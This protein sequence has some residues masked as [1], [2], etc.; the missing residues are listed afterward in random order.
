[1]QTKRYTIE[2][3]LLPEDRLCS[4]IPSSDRRTHR[5]RGLADFAKLADFVE[6]DELMEKFLPSSQSHLYTEHYVY[7]MEYFHW[8][9]WVSCLAILTP[10][11]C[12]PAL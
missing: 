11:S 10:S 5:I 2:F 8:P 6:L 7:G 4:Q 3:F 12:T 9:D 1:M